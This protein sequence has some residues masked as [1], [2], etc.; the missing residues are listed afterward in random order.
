MIPAIPIAAMAFVEAGSGPAPFAQLIEEHPEGSTDYRLKLQLSYLDADEITQQLGPDPTV[1]PITVYHI[2]ILRV[3]TDVSSTTYTYEKFTLK[4]DVPTKRYILPDYSGFTDDDSYHPIADLPGCW[5][6]GDS[7]YTE[8]WF[9]LPGQFISYGC[10]TLH[11]DCIERVI[12]RMIR[13][14]AIPPCP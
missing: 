6:E 8:E 10:Y 13:L 12:E 11:A 5:N 3:P 1:P 14:T 4:P 7:S 2:T 9:W